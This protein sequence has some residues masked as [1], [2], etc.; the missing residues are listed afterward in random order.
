MSSN[1]LIDYLLKDVGKALQDEYLPIRPSLS[2][3]FS[4]SNRFKQ[5]AYDHRE[6]IRN[7]IKRCNGVYEALE[8]VRTELEIGYLLHRNGRYSVEYEKNY[9]QGRTP[10]FA[11]STDGQGLFN[12]EVKRLRRAT[13]AERYRNWLD[14]L[15]AKLRTL[16]PGFIVSVRALWQEEDFDFSW[17]EKPTREFTAMDDPR[18]LP[19]RLIASKQE[20]FQFVE[21]II[22][23]L[24]CQQF[25]GY[26]A[27]S[28]RGFEH[29]LELLVYKATDPYVP[30]QVPFHSDISFYL[31]GEERKLCDII[32][33]SLGQMVPRLTNFLMIRSVSNTYDTGNVE[34][35]LDLMRQEAEKG[36]NE[37]F[38]MRDLAG[39]DD[40]R[41]K[42]KN[43]SAI[44][45]RSNRFTSRKGWIEESQRILLWENPDADNRI[46]AVERNFLST[47]PVPYP[48]S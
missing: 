1:D 20:T 26:K 36:N 15:D 3:W 30:T 6:K 48:N 31:F 28:L 8:D 25:E 39:V 45:F 13:L 29:D 5:F 12:V 14:D 9:G 21:E 37:F 19:N 7:K 42:M 47:L 46:T 10:D 16:P 11:V 24:A 33:K 43:L 2:Y 44:W 35:A 27:F 23:D 41:A 4:E 40:Y 38:R 17:K 32:G 22:N 34:E 18:H